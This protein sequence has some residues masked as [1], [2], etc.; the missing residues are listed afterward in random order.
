MH[1]QFD[2]RR[3][4]ISPTS[5]PSTW[6]AHQRVVRCQLS[7]QR[8]RLL[9]QLLSQQR[10]EALT[11]SPIRAKIA[12]SGPRGSVC[13]AFRPWLDL[14]PHPKTAAHNRTNSPAYT[15]RRSHSHSYGQTDWVAGWLADACVCTCRH[16]C[17]HRLLL[18]R[19][20]WL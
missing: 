5:Q 9:R 10:T 4:R 18:L 6:L 12:L 8:Q 13:V 17:R 14:Q 16:N 19:I 15:P 11:A 1:A 3:C 7:A 20:C 2:R